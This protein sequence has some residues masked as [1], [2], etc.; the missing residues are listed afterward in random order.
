M[1][2]KSLPLVVVESPK[3]AKVLQAYFA[4]QYDVIASYGHVRNLP[5]RSG[6]V[7]PDK[8]FEMVWETQSKAV[9]ELIKKARGASGVIL[10]ADPDREGEAICYHIAEILHERGI[11]CPVTRVRF[12]SLEKTAI[13]S[14]LEAQ[15]EIDQNLTGAYFAR[16]AMDYLVGFSI[17]PLLWRKVPGNR[18]A[19]RV[20]SVGLRIIIDREREIEMFQSRDYWVVEPV[21][22]LEKG[23]FKLSVKTWCG[24]P[25][26]QFFY[27]S[28]EHAQEIAGV[29]Q[30]REWRVGD[31]RERRRELRPNP[32]FITATLQQDASNRLGLR[33]VNTMRIAQELYEGVMV[34][35]EL[36]GLITYMRTD[37]TNIHPDAA[38]QCAKLILG[39]WGAEYVSQER[40]QRR[41]KNAQNAHEAI[42]PVDYRITPEIAAKYLDQ[43]H[44]QVYRLVWCRAVA[45]QMS[46][47]ILYNTTVDILNE[48]SVLQ[49]KG[50]RYEFRGY[51]VAYD[52]DS[53]DEEAILP[54][55]R[56]DQSVYLERVEIDARKTQPPGRY[57][58]AGLIKKLEQE[59]IGRPSTYDKII[60]VLQYR[61]YAR[62]EG[63]V[64][65]P[66]D[67]GWIV[68]GFLEEWFAQYVANEFTASVEE[69]LDSV[70]SG[71]LFWQDVMRE[72]WSA[73]DAKVNAARELAPEDVQAALQK[74]VGAYLIKELE[75]PKCGTG[76]PLVK[77]SKTG[78]FVGCTNYPECT[79]V[80]ALT[81]AGRILYEDNNER[82]VLKRGPYGMYAMWEQCGKKVTIPASIKEEKVIWAMVRAWQDLPRVLGHD[83]FGAEISLGI[84]RF[85]V[86][87]K[88]VLDGAVEYRNVPQS[89]ELETFTLEDALARLARPRRIVRGGFGSV[90]TLSSDKKGKVKKQADEMVRKSTSKK[91]VGRGVATGKAREGGIKV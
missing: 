6:S 69:R 43:K 50:T 27:N 3:K 30:G 36:R 39:R 68:C 58:E 74:H 4:D 64:L 7:L 41:G 19:G 18:S 67:R 5:S 90:A 16:L 75:C 32:P 53:I 34:E 1:L 2:R 56:A 91:R 26:G 60:S 88:R 25:V 49:A 76:R 40:V 37:S 28:A 42:R 14:A 85:G 23:E 13:A 87:I 38:D 66:E 71:D 52:D 20:Q 45:S 72:F 9:A 63:K 73:F 82:V 22:I 83:P 8:N 86:Y 24:D 35:G 47:A 31:V 29:I 17:S 65:I 12:N 44:A 33:P 10:A 15:T 61:G 21:A 11:D 54:T 80:R 79:W 55:M 46:N 77:Y 78:G 84:G 48:G 51:K 81:Q 57:T 89:V 62:R 70:A 59:G